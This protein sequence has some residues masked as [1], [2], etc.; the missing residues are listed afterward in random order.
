MFTQVEPGTRVCV[1]DGRIG[2]FEQAV[3]KPAAG[4]GPADRQHT[5]HRRHS[6]TD[7][8]QPRQGPDAH[9]VLFTRSRT[10]ATGEGNPRVRT[11]GGSRTPANAG[12]RAD[13]VPGRQPVGR[14]RAHRGTGQ[15]APGQGSGPRG[16]TG[17]VHG[18]AL[19]ETVPRAFAGGPAITAHRLGRTAAVTRRR[20]VLSQ[21]PPLP[22]GRAPSWPSG[23]RP[24]RISSVWCGC[25]TRADAGWLYG[26]VRFHALVG[27][28]GEA[29]GYAA[30]PC[31]GFLPTPALTPGGWSDRRMTR[32]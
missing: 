7:A 18:V 14:R 13:D 1:P 27:T 8:A 25:T 26:C 9:G 11:G 22:A 24:G 4:R 31:A 21:T 29:C 2:R 6:R 17:P 3:R 12:G 10:G 30:S 16:A 15:G 20:T 28:Q 23:R 32:R 19:H 5:A